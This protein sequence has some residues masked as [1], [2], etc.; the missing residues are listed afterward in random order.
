MRPRI[1]KK[2]VYTTSESETKRNFAKQNK[3]KKIICVLPIFGTKKKISF[4]EY[5]RLKEA[6]LN[7]DIVE[8]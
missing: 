4:K 2:L 8:E 7:V 5:M 1:N 6:G 3:R